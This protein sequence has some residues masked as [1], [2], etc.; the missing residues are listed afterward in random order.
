M[1]KVTN[2][3]KRNASAYKYWRNNDKRELDYFQCMADFGVIISKA[4]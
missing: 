1:N 2:F 3:S 4:L